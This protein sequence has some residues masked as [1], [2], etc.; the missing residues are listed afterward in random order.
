MET[1]KHNLLK[2]FGRIQKSLKI[3]QKIYPMTVM[4]AKKLRTNA[5]QAKERQHSSFQ[6]ESNLR[7][8]SANWNEELSQQQQYAQLLQR[9][10]VN[11]ARSHE[12]PEQRATYS[13]P[14]QFRIQGYEQ[15]TQ[16]FTAFATELNHM[17]LNENQM[18]NQQKTPQGFGQKYHEFNQRYYEMNQ[19]PE[20]ASSQ[21]DGEDFNQKSYNGYGYQLEEDSLY[22]DFVRWV[23]Q[24]SM[25][26]H[27]ENQPFVSN[28]QQFGYVLPPS[29]V[30]NP[31][32]SMRFRPIYYGPYYAQECS[33]LPSSPSANGHHGSGFESLPTEINQTNTTRQPQR[34]RPPLQLQTTSPQGLSAKD[35]AHTN[36]TPGRKES[37]EGPGNVG[38]AVS[39]LQPTVAKRK[40]VV[41]GEC[42]LVACQYC[43]KKHLKC[44]GNQPCATCSRVKTECI[45]LSPKRKKALGKLFFFVFNGLYSELTYFLIEQ[46]ELLKE[47]EVSI[48][49]S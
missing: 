11:E 37:P 23:E 47:L 2:S 32:R 46:L 1:N 10:F 33:P 21:H 45:Y 28:G 20:T 14:T 22:P 41:R 16:D 31:G 15:L 25:E 26:S 40:R 48:C 44:D 43:R 42:T 9:N 18:L 6:G 39:T 5:K 35:P 4:M 38:A 34:S 7:K 36:S 27:N 30:I 12:I 24:T 13:N 3:C 8:Q 49:F 29:P 17:Q 19:Q